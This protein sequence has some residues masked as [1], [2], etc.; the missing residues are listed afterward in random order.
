MVYI[1]ELFWWFE[2]VKPD[3][4]Q[5]RDLH[6]IRDGIKYFLL[7]YICLSFIKLLINIHF[8]H[9]FSEIAAAAEEFQIPYSHLQR[10]QTWFHDNIELR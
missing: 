1:A 2:S 7:S 9:V 10:P 4:V 8:Y 5:P 6:E 3:F